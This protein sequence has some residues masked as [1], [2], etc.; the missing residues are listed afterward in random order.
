MEIEY[1]SFT[2]SLF[3]EVPVLSQKSWE[4]MYMCVEDISTIF[5]W[6]LELLRQCDNFFHFIINCGGR[7]DRD[8]IWI[9]NYLCNQCLSPPTL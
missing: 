7:R 3:I 9:Y 5:N 6:I 4:V 1:T 2:P 8:R